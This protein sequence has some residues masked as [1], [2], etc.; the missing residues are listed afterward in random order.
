MAEEFAE[1]DRRAIAYAE[2]LWMKYSRITTPNMLT[3]ALGKDDRWWSNWMQKDSVVKAF[4]RRAIPMGVTDGSLSPEQLALAN[5]LLDFADN[6]S[7]KKKLADLNISSSKYQSWLK[8]KP[9]MEYCRVRSENLLTDALPEAHMA[10]IDN[11]RRGDLGSLKL[12]YEISGRFSA[13]SSGVDVGNLIN[14]ILEILM[15]HIRD[16][17]VLLAISNDFKSLDTG[18]NLNTVMGEVVPPVAK[19]IPAEGPISL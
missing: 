5:A 19:E 8:Y 9:F 7:F 2:S 14:N 15:K 16:T 10:L 1:L 12:F 3:E 4:E 13:N 18:A 6:R 17:D 11:V